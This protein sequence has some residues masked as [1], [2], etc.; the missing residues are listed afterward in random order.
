[1]RLVSRGDLTPTWG[2][3][4]RRTEYFMMDEWPTGVLEARKRIEYRDVWHSPAGSMVQFTIDSPKGIPTTPYLVSQTNLYLFAGRASGFSVEEVHALLDHYAL[5]DRGAA[6][7]GKEPC[8]PPKDIRLVSRGD[9]VPAWG[10]VRQQAS[11]YTPEG[12]RDG[13]VEAGTFVDCQKVVGSSKGPMAVCLLEPADGTTVARRLIN[14]KD[15]HLFTGTFR[16]LARGQQQALRTYYELDGRIMLRKNELLQASA[17]KNPHFSAYQAAYRELTAHIRKSRDEVFRRDHAVGGADR[18][19]AQE[20]LFA[21]R[22]EERRL[23]TVLEE[24]GKRFTTWRGEH[25]GELALP[26]HDEEITDLTRLK[27]TLSS[28]LPGLG[29]N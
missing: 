20:R 14:T 5:G 8:P 6:D 17:A 21:A 10:I 9:A 27:K 23:R 2:L 19:Q 15:L 24:A 29:L 7:G 12:V 26:E 13:T 28:M 16:I 25:T 4:C 3:V 11:R 18:V 1:M 22:M